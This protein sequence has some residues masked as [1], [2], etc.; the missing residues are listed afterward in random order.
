M[1]FNLS[2]NCHYDSIVMFAAGIGITPMIYLTQYITECASLRSLSNSKDEHSLMSRPSHITIVVTAREL[3][4]FKI[5]N[6]NFK[7]FLRDSNIQISLRLFCTSSPTDSNSSTSIDDKMNIV[8]GGLSRASE[9][10]NNDYAT[11]YAESNRVN[12]SVIDSAKYGEI[13]SYSRP[14]VAAIL[15]S[16]CKNKTP[17][18]G[19]VGVCVC[20][21]SSFI[22]T[23]KDACIS[24][25]ATHDCSIDMHEE[26][27]QF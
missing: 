16:V 15:S 25:E 13:V 1:Q 11:G 24:V 7:R 17:P 20:G 12:S 14:D 26:V 4:L 8:L 5:F 2:Q 10:S 9:S 18:G 19:N 21:P 6:E 22:D 3:S 27:F 23:V